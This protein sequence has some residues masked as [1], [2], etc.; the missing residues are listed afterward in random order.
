VAPPPQIRRSSDLD[1]FRRRAAPWLLEAEAE[2]NLI[3]SL[4]DQLRRGRRYGEDDPYFFTVEK[5]GGV[6]G[7]ALRT[8]PHFPLALTRMPG[9]ALLGPLARR[10]AEIDPELTAVMGPRQVVEPFAE[11]WTLVTG[12]RAEPGRRQRIYELTEV[13]PPERPVSGTL[14]RAGIEDLELTTHWGA[15]FDRETDLPRMDS[16]ARARAWIEDGGLFLWE[17]D[18]EGSESEPVAQPVCMAVAVGSTR[19]GARIGFVYTPPEH[20]GRGY[21][22]ACTAA[23]S[24]LLLERGR[25]FC[26]LYTDLANPTSNHIYQRIGYRPLCDVA[27]ARFFAEKGAETSGEGSRSES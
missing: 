8:P 15:A 5:G 16:R 9:E 20:R 22:T 23:L 18:A 2:H 11:E 24:G 4:I 12:R 21:G 6:V 19:H 3:L 7:C 25:R 26:C 1:A 10:V 17:D 14:R 27:E 13:I